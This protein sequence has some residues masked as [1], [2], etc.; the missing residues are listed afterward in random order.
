MS[1]YELVDY[2]QPEYLDGAMARFLVI[3][4]DKIMVAY[5][6]RRED[7]ELFLAAHTLSGQAERSR[8]FREL[9]K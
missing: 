8:Q 9:L 5:F 4:P 1:K 7:A 2:G 6:K 3:D